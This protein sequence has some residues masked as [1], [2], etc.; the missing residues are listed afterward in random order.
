[1]LKR[2]FKESLIYGLSRYIGKF[3]GVF[4]LPLYT[5]VLEPSD[6]GILD[7]LGTITVVST[8][9]IVSGTDSALSY[10]YYRKEFTEERPVMISS[11]LWLRIF[12]A[13]IITALVFILSGTISSLLFGK[14]LSLF[15][16]ITAL[17]I[18]FQAIQSFLF[19]L[20]RFEFRQWLYTIVSSAGILINIL[21]T[22]YFV[23]ILKQGVY[24]ALMAA[25]ISYGLFFIYTI[26][27]VFN[28]YGVRLSYSWIKKI[29]SY[30]FPLIGTGIAIWILNSTDRYFIDHYVSLSSVG[31]YAVGMKLAN[32]IGMIA[33]ALQLAWGPFA[34]DIQNDK[35]AKKIYS[36]V[37]LIY[38]ILNL[39]GV[40]LISM[41]SIDI[42]KVF[43]QPE[44]YS[45]KVVV[46]FLCLSVVLSS[47]YFIVAIGINITKKLQHT[48]WITVS[49]AILNIIMNFILTPWLGVVGAALAIMTA[50]L[51]IFTLTY[52][53]SQKFYP[54]SYNIVKILIVFLPGAIIVG[55]SY[56]YDFSLQLRLFVSLI[57]LSLTVIYYYR[58]FRESYELT[59]IINKI[60]NIKK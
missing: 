34:M 23:L 45:A 36:Q 32:F 16:Y 5:A 44:Y 12:I 38:F 56:T 39:M 18:L 50:N 60:R 19:D 13:I 6:Y 37:F 21:L 9:L 28:R 29:F 20:L 8:F 24:G 27:Y 58:S 52:F 25:F 53:I 17:T 55:L 54:V 33:G 42:L 40:Y 35:N 59:K 48:I 51:L 14:D 22:I 7:L 1:L 3:I 43:T 57:F 10:F 49:A 15:L 30:G 26:F 46:P 47:A 11:S 2:L 31:I 41:F 4:L